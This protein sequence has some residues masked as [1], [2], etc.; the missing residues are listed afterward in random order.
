LLEVAVAL[1]ETSE[2]AELSIDRGDDSSSAATLHGIVGQSPALGRV[3]RLV[4]TV[5]TTDAAVLIRG[6]TGTGKELIAD[7]ITPAEPTPGRPAPEIQLHRA[8]DIPLLVRHFVMRKT[9][10][11]IAGLRGAA[12]RLGLKRTTLLAKMEKLGI[13]VADVVP[14]V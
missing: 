5:A 12:M 8:E 1:H 14:A 2:I 4:E 7:L 10:G 3:L 11:I 9:N 13:T 6:E